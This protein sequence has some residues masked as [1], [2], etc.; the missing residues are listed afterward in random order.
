MLKCV[1]CKSTKLAPN[2]YSQSK[3]KSHT[4]LM[5]IC[6]DCKVPFAFV[7]NTQDI[8]FD[9][10]TLKY[11]PDMYKSFLIMNKSNLPW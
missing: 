8:N 4:L 5:G 6:I 2:L 3:E 10:T 11:M 1:K 9:F 7:F